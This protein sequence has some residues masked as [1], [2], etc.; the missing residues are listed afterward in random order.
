MNIVEYLV[1]LNCTVCTQTDVCTS[2]NASSLHGPL[3]VT[4]TVIPGT[5]QYLWVSPV[6]PFTATRTGRIKS[7]PSFTA[8]AC[9]FSLMHNHK[10][11]GGGFDQMN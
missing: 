9:S 2:R 5:N 4:S 8:V 3:T 6:Y 11:G 1:S 7:S 10:K